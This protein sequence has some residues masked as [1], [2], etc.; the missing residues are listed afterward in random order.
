MI[1]WNGVLFHIDS[2][3]LE[4]GEDQFFYEVSD[5]L[6]VQ[7]AQHFVNRRVT[8]GGCKVGGFFRVLYTG[9]NVLDVVM[10]AP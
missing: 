1:F 2:C 3:A 7:Y 10:E 8:P 9:I 4:S 5:D 6:F